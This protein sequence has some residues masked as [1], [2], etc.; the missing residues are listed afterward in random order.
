MKRDVETKFC[1]LIYILHHIL[2][3]CITHVKT[4]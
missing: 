2:L 3:C 1:E 4:L